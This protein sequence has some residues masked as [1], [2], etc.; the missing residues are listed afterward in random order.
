[1]QRKIFLSFLLLSDSSNVSM[2]TLDFN[3]SDKN[4][5]K[6]S[7]FALFLN[8][9]FIAQSKCTNFVMIINLGYERS[10]SQTR[11]KACGIILEKAVG[12]VARWSSVLKF[13][14]FLAV[15]K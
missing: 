3:N 4:P 8:R 14:V 7:K 13:K 1:M 5:S 10:K 15:F 2:V 12:A 9:F 6:M 11:I